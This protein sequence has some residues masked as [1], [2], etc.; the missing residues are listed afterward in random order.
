MVL[1]CFY[2]GTPLIHITVS[3]FSLFSNTRNIQVISYLYIISK[4]I[5]RLATIFSDTTEIC[6]EITF[7]LKRKTVGYSYNMYF[8]SW[9]KTQMSNMAMIKSLLLFWEHLAFCSSILLSFPT[10]FKAPKH[11]IFVFS[12]ADVLFATGRMHN[13]IHLLSSK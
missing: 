5:K 6:T 2:F 11:I 8:L 13:N 10:S 1:H 4:W 12:V 9:W 7:Y 3:D